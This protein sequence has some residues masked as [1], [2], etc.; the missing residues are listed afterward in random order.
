MVTGHA[1]R[2]MPQAMTQ[3]GR[4]LVRVKAYGEELGRLELKIDTEK[5]APVSWEWKRIPIDSTKIQPDAEVARLVK[6]WEDEVT[7]RVD[8]PMAVS[9]RDFTRSEVKKL[10]EQAM[11]EE[12][13]ADFAFMNQGGVRDILPKGQLKERHVWDIMPFDNRV[14]VGTFK[15]RELPAVVVGERKVEADREYT[16]AVSDFTAANQET[17]ENLRVK[18]L[19]FPRDVG[20]MRDLLID[21]FQKKKVVE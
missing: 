8:R 1:H 21:W 9:K 10:M 12:S 15:G 2:G 4:V 5:K 3:D 19:E 6:R 13:G 17:A 16:L 7:A 14:V 20:L 11:R 18:G